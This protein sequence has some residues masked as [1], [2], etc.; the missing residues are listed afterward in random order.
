MT[1]PE[2]PTPELR[3]APSL[4]FNDPRRAP[5]GDFAAT[6]VTNGALTR[7]AV[8]GPASSWD[9]VSDFCLTY[10]GF[11][12]WND[13]PELATRAVQTWTRQ[14]VLPAGL[15]ELRACLFYEQRRWHRFDEE[16]S[17]RSA[18]Y[19]RAL[20]EGV[21]ALLPVPAA[22]PS[23]PGVGPIADPRVRVA[24]EAHVR[25]V[26]AHRV[27]P[28][29]PAMAGRH[30]LDADDVSALD[31]TA[32]LDGASLSDRTGA[33]PLR[34]RLRPVPDVASIRPL[35]PHRARPV[36]AVEAHVRLV[37]SIEAEGRGMTVLTTA[38]ASARHAQA[39]HPSAYRPVPHDVLHSGGAELRPMPSADPLPKPPVISRRPRPG[40]QAES[41][42]PVA[43]MSV[44][45]PV[46]AHVGPPPRAVHE[47][48]GT[49]AATA[50]T[51]KTAT[52]FVRDDDGYRTWLAAHPQGFVLNVT[53]GA[54]AASVL[55]RAE[56]PTLHAGAATRQQA[57]GRAPKVCGDA[58]A[59]EAWCAAQGITAT[60]CRHCL[61]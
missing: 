60:A 19:I 51:A 8:P 2:R 6:A 43:R 18:V 57:T 13:L 37:S 47:T 12:Y 4:R 3:A 56:C 22:R 58:G 30:G 16:P 28:L 48:P 27:T 46:T 15:D 17:G 11:A 26:P 39:R 38:D 1:L 35:A 42:G 32:L 9:E 5:A 59:L 49:P 54:A 14:G 23:V 29:V 20:V 41:R 61:G 52:P 24:P 10:D 36:P 25:I 33:E 40:R 7:A 45:P 34:P 50:T 53:R 31:D 55:H 21:G 44:L